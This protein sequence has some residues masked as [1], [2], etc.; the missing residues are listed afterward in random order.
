MQWSLL[1]VLLVGVGGAIGSIV[2]FGI[3]R[4]FVSQVGT[5][6]FPWPTFL[7]NVSGSFLLG[8]L[9]VLLLERMSTARREWHLLL[10]TGFCG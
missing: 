1:A 7:I 10:G 8:F 5:T 2:R 9:S 4:L 6:T 3:N